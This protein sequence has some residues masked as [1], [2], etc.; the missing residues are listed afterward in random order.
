VSPKISPR[1]GETRRAQHRQDDRHIDPPDAVI[2][3]V[4]EYVHIARTVAI[5]EACV[6]KPAECFR[7]LQ[8]AVSDRDVLL[9]DTR[10]ETPGERPLSPFP[11]ACLPHSGCRD[12][13]ATARIRGTIAM[14]TMG[15]AGGCASALSTSTAVVNAALQ[16]IG[17]DGPAVTGIY[18]TLVCQQALSGKPVIFFG[19]TQGR[20]STTKP[21]F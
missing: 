18:P 6:G 17:D 14:S 21:G 9:L 7:V 20:G 2:D 8:D 13:S 1:D 16:Q 5:P 4:P 15:D 10:G 12:G 11:H 3:L 19:F